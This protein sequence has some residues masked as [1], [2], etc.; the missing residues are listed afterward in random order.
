MP[1]RN[2]TLWCDCSPVCDTEYGTET[3]RTSPE[4]VVDALA[5][6]EGVNVLELTPLSDAIDPD[7][8]LQLFDQHDGTSKLPEAIL[9]FSVNNWN[10][11]ARNDGRIRV[12]DA[13][14]P[15]DPAPVFE[16][17]DT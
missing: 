5:T 15:S 1:S 9:S 14:K 10:V 6:A 3:E 11:F 17:G 4:A 16:K 8:L 7:G 12:C 13:T 2:L